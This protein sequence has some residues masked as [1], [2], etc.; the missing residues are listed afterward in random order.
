MKTFLLVLFIYSPGKNEPKS[1]DGIFFENKP[2]LD[3]YVKENLPS[4]QKY[5]DTV[6]KMNR[7]EKLIIK[8][9]IYDASLINGELEF[10]KI[11]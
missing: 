9:K 2:S 8:H 6:S 11:K 4:R 7:T 5:I 1:I 10:E 3:A